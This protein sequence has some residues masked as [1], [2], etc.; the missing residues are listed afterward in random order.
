MRIEMNMMNRMNSQIMLT[1]ACMAIVLG[2]IMLTGCSDRNTQAENEVL[3]IKQLVQDY[4]TGKMEDASASITSRQLIVTGSDDKKMT[5][6]LPENDFF[7]SIAPYVNE[8]HPCATHSLT[9]CRGEMMNEEFT[10]SIVDTDGNSVL[11]QTVKSQANG[12][13]DLWLS[14]DKT[15]RITV[16]HDGRTAKSEFSTFDKDNT[17]ITTIK[18]I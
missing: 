16:D 12:F 4:S 1:A 15:Y 17:C 10:I 6:E 3:D 9:G 11:D 18:L 2:M 14:R 7:V 13:I 5:Y 8:T